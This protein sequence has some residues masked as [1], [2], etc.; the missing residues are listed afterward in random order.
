MARTPL[1]QA[2]SETA[3]DYYNRSEDD[4]RRA[5][6]LEDEARR[7]QAAIS[8]RSYWDAETRT[9]NAAD[10]DANVT[11][12]LEAEKAR[13]LA[14]PE[15]QLRG[16]AISLGIEG[17]ATAPIATLKDAVRTMQVSD[18]EAV[19]LAEARAD[20]NVDQTLLPERQALREKTEQPDREYAKGEAGY[21]NTEFT[22]ASQ[23]LSDVDR[24]AMTA[25]QG[26]VAAIAAA[27][28]ARDPKLASVA[29]DEQV[30]AGDMP[31]QMQ[32]EDGLK[33]LSQNISAKSRNAQAQLMR[34]QSML[35]GAA[36]NARR[37]GASY[38]ES[39]TTGPVVETPKVLTPEER[40]EEM[41]RQRAARTPP[42]PA[43]APVREAPPGAG[44]FAPPAAG[45]GSFM[46]STAP[47][48]INPF[49]NDWWKTKTP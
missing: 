14:L 16:L 8:D 33:Q 23:A 7:R 3:R 17:A 9:R 5:L 18:M 24:E 21:W 22:K 12:Q 28:R 38:W 47:S 13:L 30:I 44:M 43:P 27:A 31:A 48:G 46:P 45:R 42:A 10:A 11:R 49:G 19:R 20:L 34:A 25:Q 1:A 41:M 32:L 35:Q 37:V 40:F 36:N 29:S 26:L 15:A 6:A 4:R 2:I 39:P